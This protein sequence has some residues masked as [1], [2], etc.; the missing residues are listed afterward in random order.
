M[1]NTSAALGPLELVG[2]IW[3]VGDS[4]RPG[5]TWLEFRAEGLYRQSAGGGELIPWPRIMLGV[6]VYIGRGYPRTGQYTLA[7]ML[8]NLPGPFRGRGGGHLDM[9]LR[10]PYEDRKLTFDRHARAYRL[11]DTFLLEELLSHVVAADEAHRL[12]DPD[13]LGQ[14]VD[15]LTSLSARMTRRRLSEA[16]AEAWRGSD[17]PSGG[18]P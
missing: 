14:V 1:G 10:D 12:G 9:T 2:G 17:G 8:G 18:R 13:L 3:V 7:G 6:G 11:L 16:V 4:R 15:R 5:G